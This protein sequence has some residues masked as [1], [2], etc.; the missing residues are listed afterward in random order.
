M[1][2]KILLIIL[3]LGL[4]IHV[5]G[6]ADEIV[7]MEDVDKQIISQMEDLEEDLEIPLGEEAEEEIK[8]EI[9]EVE[10]PE[11]KLEMEGFSLCIDAGHGISTDKRK[12]AI[13]P[14]SDKT[15]P[16]FVSGTRGLNQTEE[17]LNLISLDVLPFT[18]SFVHFSEQA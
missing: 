12:E 15:K 18:S 13:A 17:E 16:A 4:L 2:L 6:K 14:N 10:E 5:S 9:E 8:E 7:V 11:E 1:K 3:S